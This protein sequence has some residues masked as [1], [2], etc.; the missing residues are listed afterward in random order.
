MGRAHADSPSQ[1]D[2][3]CRR[4][5]RLLSSGQAHLPWQSGS[6][7]RNR[8]DASTHRAG[9]QNRPMGRRCQVQSCSQTP[10]ARSGPGF[11]QAPHRTL[12]SAEVPWWWRGGQ[13]PRNAPL[14]LRGGLER[15]EGCAVIANGQEPAAAVNIRGCLGDMCMAQTHFARPKP[16]SQYSGS[17]Y[18]RYQMWRA[19][20]GEQNYVTQLCFKERVI[21]RPYPAASSP[22]TPPSARPWP[23]PRGPC[24]GTRG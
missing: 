24:G 2:R 18:G 15:C 21:P 3:V 8:T 17:G 13:W 1:R 23:R 10:T 22:Q 16:R 14:A 7:Q 5:R 19:K 11:F 6:C 4:L 9:I 20:S 12:Q